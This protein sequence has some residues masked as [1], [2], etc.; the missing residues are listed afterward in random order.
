ML[1]LKPWQTS[2]LDAV[3]EMPSWEQHP[4]RWRQ[5]A[6]FREQLFTPYTEPRALR[7]RYQSLRKTLSLDPSILCSICGRAL[8]TSSIRDQIIRNS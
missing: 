3:S 5:A 7:Q 4:E 8:A 2:P 6:E 1:S